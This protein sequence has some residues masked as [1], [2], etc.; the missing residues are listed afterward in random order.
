MDSSNYSS[1]CI[2]A[3][4]SSISFLDMNRLLVAGFGMD[5]SYFVS[6]ANCSRLGL[7]ESVRSSRMEDLRREEG[8]RVGAAGDFRADSGCGTF[9]CSTLP[10]DYDR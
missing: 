6:G 9:L 4:S 8:G 10:D 1:C 7:A 2:R 5:A 3:I